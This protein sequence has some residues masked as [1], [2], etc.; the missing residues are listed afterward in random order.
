MSGCCGSSLARIRDRVSP[1]GEVGRVDGQPA[2]VGDLAFAGLRRG[3][4]T[5]PERAGLGFLRARVLGVT[6]NPLDRTTGLGEVFRLRIG[7]GGVELGGRA[8]V[9][10]EPIRR[11][12]ERA[13]VELGLGAA[14]GDGVAEERQPGLEA[15]EQLHRELVLAPREGRARTHEAHLGTIL[16]GLGESVD[17]ARRLVPPFDADRLGPGRGRRERLRGRGGVDRRLGH[18]RARVRLGVGRGLRDH[19]GRHRRRRPRRVAAAARAEDRHRDAE[20]SPAQIARANAKR[21]SQGAAPHALPEL[22]HAETP[23]AVPLHFSGHSRG[24]RSVDD[25][26]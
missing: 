6:E 3:V 16:L 14:L 5:N 13:G 12:L 7:L 21:R 19:A 20:E 23:A 8:G 25:A 10:G 1:G 24:I 18:R 22:I 2:H 26:T 11:V 9:L 15:F 4:E 17:G